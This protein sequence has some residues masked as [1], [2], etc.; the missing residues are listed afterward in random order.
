MEKRLARLEGL[1]EQ[2]DRRLNH[3]ESEIKELRTEIRRLP[4]MMLGMLAVIV[5]AVLFS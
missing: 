5:M 4:W 1:V 3:I 2:M